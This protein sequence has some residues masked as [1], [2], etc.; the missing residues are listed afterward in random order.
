MWRCAENR[1][2]INFDFVSPEG[3]GPD[4]ERIEV[5]R[6]NTRQH[7]LRLDSLYASMT[8]VAIAR[9]N[10]ANKRAWAKNKMWEARDHAVWHELER[11]KNEV[12]VNETT[13][14]TPST[15]ARAAGS[16]AGSRA[17][18]STAHAV[19]SAK[20]YDDVARIQP[21]MDEEDSGVVMP[22]HG[23]R[24]IAW[25]TRAY[26]RG[27]IEAV[28]GAENLIEK[29]QAKR[30]A[31]RARKKKRKAELR[32]CV[33]QLERDRVVDPPSYNDRS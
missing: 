21:E 8:P 26:D 23:D 13:L 19:Y 16:V 10:K 29:R 20:F 12:Q 5:L 14:S 25:R 11:R 2:K 27:E 9:W 30:R 22:S 32:D 15:A 33:K 3:D 4:A 7:E 28:Q 31:A 18:G 6:R 17:Q 24:L 1:Q